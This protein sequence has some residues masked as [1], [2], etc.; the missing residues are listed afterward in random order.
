V[1]S[2]KGGVDMIDPNDFL[3]QLIYDLPRST[4]KVT[5][6]SRKEAAQLLDFAD[7]DLCTCRDEY[8]T[9]RYSASVFHLEQACEKTYKALLL[10]IGLSPQ[11][12]PKK[13]KHDPDLMRRTVLTRSN[14]MAQIVN[15]FESE[16]D[17]EILNREE[18][19]VI[20]PAFASTE[21]IFAYISFYDER[22]NRLSTLVE[23]TL[24]QS[25]VIATKGHKATEAFR[26]LRAM[27]AAMPIFSISKFTWPHTSSSRYGGRPSLQDYTMDLGI[28]RS[29]PELATKVEAAISV[30]RR[31]YR[32]ST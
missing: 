26:H 15:S 13:Y 3:Q 22:A 2:K 16:M 14:Q 19:Q 1:A 25:N 17:D 12:E 5:R 8:K 10:L 30:I 32:P 4:V 23:A 18:P 31:E 27:V 11:G 20:N 24:R 21:T 29:I 7:I 9:N 6:G 28:V